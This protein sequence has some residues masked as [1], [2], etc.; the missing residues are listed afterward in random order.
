MADKPRILVFASGDAN[1]GGSGF[2]VLVEQSLVGNLK[3]EIIGVVSQHAKGGV[4]EKA[5]KMDIPMKHFSGPFTAKAYLKIWESNGRPWVMLSGWTKKVF[6]LP[7]ERTVNIHPAPL[8]EFG[9]PGFWGHTVHEKVMEAHAKQG[10]KSSAVTMHF[11]DTKDE[12]GLETYDTGPQIFSLPVPIRQGEDADSLGG[13]VN[14]FEHGWQWWVTNLVV[15]GEIRLEKGVV[16]V[17]LW[18]LNMPFCP[19]NCRALSADG[20]K[21]ERRR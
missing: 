19:R 9:G 20:K 16:L 11:V 2:Q 8:P 3:A 6:G 14:K 18:Y 4:W 10:L 1:G 15:N 21:N 17:P 7:M 5:K 13:Q 12:P